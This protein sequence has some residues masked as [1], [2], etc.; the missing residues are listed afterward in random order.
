MQSIGIM[1]NLPGVT[2]SVVTL[3]FI[4]RYVMLKEIGFGRGFSLLPRKFLSFLV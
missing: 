3:V 1:L 2:Y 4:F